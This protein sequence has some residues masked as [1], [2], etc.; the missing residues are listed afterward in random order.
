M[1]ACITC[2]SCLVPLLKGLL[3]QDLG[4]GAKIL[5]GRIKTGLVIVM[6]VLRV[7]T[8]FFFFL[9]TVLELT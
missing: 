3:C 8:V 1:I 5:R 7:M 9:Y 2:N 4:G 6:F